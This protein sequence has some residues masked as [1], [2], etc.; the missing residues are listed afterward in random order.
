MAE[1]PPKNEF[2]FIE[3]DAL[4][5]LEE[6]F[7]Q[8]GRPFPGYLMRKVLDTVAPGWRENHPQYKKLM[9]QEGK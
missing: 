4:A 6:E 2:Q 1:Q 7:E 9:E 3:I 8:N 5:C